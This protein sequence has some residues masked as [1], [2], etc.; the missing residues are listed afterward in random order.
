MA[1]ALT[2]V[3]L[4]IF[5]AT[6]STTVF[7]R[8]SNYS[9]QASNFVREALDA[10]RSL[11]F[12]ELVTQ[13]D[14]S[15]LGLAITRGGWMTQAV[16][17]AP[18]APNA[19]ALNTAASAKMTETGLAVVPGSYH[20]DFDFSAKIQVQKGSPIGW[21][22]GI[23]F[24]YRD[25][26][27]HYRFRFTSG[28]V[29]LDKIHHGTKTTVWSQNTAYST[30]TWYTLRVVASG[31]SIS[32]YKN[33]TLLTTQ[34]ETAFAKGD[35]AIMGISNALLYAD[36]VSLTERS[37]T[38]AW[39]FDADAVG[40]MP[41]AWQRFN[42]ADLPWGD[43]TLTISPYLAQT[44]VVQATATVTWIENGITKSSSGTTLISRWQ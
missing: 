19:L 11:P 1:I 32:L 5:T 35:L 16:S 12:S 4:S 8:R 41:L 14:G 18:S 38:T 6:V 26:A 25:A 3:I 37:I 42:Y 15:F 20:D 30:G 39:N 2:A 29:A 31:T 23:A 22:A 27:N 9:V 24:R 28:G 34:T 7:L 33:G 36:D 13:K 10:L 44:S 40:S 43:G 17:V 21:G